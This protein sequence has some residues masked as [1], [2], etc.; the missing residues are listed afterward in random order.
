MTIRLAL[1]VY[2]SLWLVWL[3]S[4][5]VRQYRGRHRG[6]RG[7]RCEGE[8]SADPWESW[9]T[10][11]TASRDRRGLYLLIWVALVIAIAAA[12]HAVHPG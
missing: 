1:G 10:R 2:L 3:L 5:Y 11:P 8:A 6:E 4:G 9:E 7:G 12:W